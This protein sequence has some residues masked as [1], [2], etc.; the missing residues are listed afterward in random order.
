MLEKIYHKIVSAGA[1]G[2]V[3]GVITIIT[4]VSVGVIMIVNGGRLLASK[5]DMEL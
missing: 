1:A 5:K 4:G 2:I 3:C